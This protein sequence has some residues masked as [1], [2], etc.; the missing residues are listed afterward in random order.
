M[1][2]KEV[3]NEVNLEEG[4]KIVLRIDELIELKKI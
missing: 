4:L 3:K 2:L 1:V